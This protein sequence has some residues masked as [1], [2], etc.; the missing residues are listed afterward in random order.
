MFHLLCPDG[1]YGTNSW[2]VWCRYLSLRWSRSR[3]RKPL[4]VVAKEDGGRRLNN[5][6]HEMRIVSR[7]R[8]PHDQPHL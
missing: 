1:D 5:T 8:S 3:S 7:G 6:S 4:R 2:V